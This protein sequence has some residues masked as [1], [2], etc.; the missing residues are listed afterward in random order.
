MQ[1][2][3]GESSREIARIV[4]LWWG[5]GLPMGFALVVS[6]CAGAEHSVSHTL[7]CNSVG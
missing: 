1:P 6:C 7:V 3:V 5:C 4:V 2:Y